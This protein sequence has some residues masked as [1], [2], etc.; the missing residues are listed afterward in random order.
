MTVRRSKLK[1]ILQ[2]IAEFL[3]QTEIVFYCLFWLMVLVVVGTI[4][5]RYVGL[6]QAQQQYFSSFILWFGPA[7]L[8]GGYTTLGIIFINLVF[9][10]IFKSVWKKENLGIIITHLGVLL[11]LVGAFLTAGFSTEG[12]MVIQEGATS[13]FVRDYHNVELVVRDTSPEDSDQ[14]TNFTQGWLKPGSVLKTDLLP[15]KIQVLSFCKNCDPIRRNQ[16]A[17][18]SYRGFAKNFDLASLP[19]DKEDE[20]N[21]AGIFFKIDGADT[22][23]NG[24]YALLEFMP[25]AQ[26]LRVGGK[27]YELEIRRARTYLP[28]RIHLIDFEKQIYPGTNKARS[29]KSV[30]TLIDEGIQQRSV[31]QMNQPLRYKNYTFFQASFIEG[32]GQETT[33]LAVV[34]NVG[35][36]F[37]Y[38]SSLIMCIGLLVHLLIQ[39]PKL[40]FKAK[41]R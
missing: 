8:P 35:R 4:A 31:I 22:L 36:L 12:S 16:P 15:F 40:I 10:L 25:V 39:V 3:T 2:N 24:T 33:V 27:I 1:K 11:L 23:T 13:N 29:Y 18:L 5:Q 38:I 34:K 30:V 28:F 14:E 41:S 37:P 7:P 26:T 17:D 19:L 21:R 9:F 20:R 32:D 6:F